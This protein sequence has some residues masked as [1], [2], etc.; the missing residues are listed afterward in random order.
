[1]SAL[2]AI[3]AAPIPPG[4]KLLLVLLLEQGAKRGPSGFQS[5]GPSHAQPKR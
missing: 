4:A 1:V 3:L 2:L 5:S